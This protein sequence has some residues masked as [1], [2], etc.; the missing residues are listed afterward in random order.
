[1][2]SLSATPRLFSLKEYY[3]MGRAGLFRDDRVELVE[4]VVVKMAPADFLHDL[5]IRY[6]TVVLVKLFSDTHAV[7]CQIGLYMGEKTELL[8]DFYLSPQKHT[9]ECDRRR[10]KPNCP[11]LVIEVSNLSLRYDLRE[12]LSLYARNQI[13]EYWVLD[14]RKRRLLV[15]LG[16]QEDTA[17]FVGMGYARVQTYKEDQSVRPAF[18][19]EV[20]IRVAD[21]LGPAIPSE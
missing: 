8:P 10:R 17:K 9:D 18:A 16:P 14:V 2:R 11:D 6:A 20:E 4:G 7:G 1:M 19:P 12:K 13:P 3:A 15:H 5:A 21:L